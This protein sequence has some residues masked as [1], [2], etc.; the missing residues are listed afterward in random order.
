M[1]LFAEVT[2]NECIIISEVI[3]CGS[4]LVMGLFNYIAIM[5]MQYEML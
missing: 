2:E 1:A 3:Y 4:Q 5:T